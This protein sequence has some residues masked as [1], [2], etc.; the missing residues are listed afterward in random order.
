VHAHPDIIAT[1][2]ITPSICKAERVQE[3]A[4]DVAPLAL[5]IL[6]GVHATFMCQQVLA[7]APQVNTIVRG[8]NEEI[9]LPLV[10]AANAGK[11]ANPP[12]HHQGPR[13]PGRRA[14]R[15]HPRRPPPSRISDTTVARNRKAIHRRRAADIFTDAQFIVGLADEHAETLKEPCR[16]ARG[17]NPDL[18][19]WA[20]RT[21][22]PSARCS[23]NCGA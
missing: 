12:R 11:W 7:E 5:R 17:C 19:T 8:E 9:L 23:R 22:G 21:P 13:R 15:R 4:R 18:A 14:D 3:I 2:A 6:G 20:M 1:T 16:R 10:R